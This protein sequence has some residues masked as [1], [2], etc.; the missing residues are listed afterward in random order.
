MQINNSTIEILSL[1]DKINEFWGVQI[2]VE[3]LFDY[4]FDTDAK[5]DKS[6]MKAMKTILH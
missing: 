3:K 1:M 4:L 6:R 2:W 5:V